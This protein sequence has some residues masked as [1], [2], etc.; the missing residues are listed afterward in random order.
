MAIIKASNPNLPT[1]NWKIV[2][3]EE[4]K[5][6]FRLTIM[7]LNK[8]S[9]APLAKTKGVIDYGFGSITL[10][11]YKK[12]EVDNK[13]DCHPDNEP[14]QRAEELGDDQQIVEAMDMELHREETGSLISLGSDEE[15]L[16]GSKGEVTAS[17]SIQ[18]QGG[19]L[20]DLTATP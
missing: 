3:Q 4:A 18:G 6:G 13:E 17:Q 12:D 1:G 11:V 7:V 5:G 14:P 16:L 20:S 10:K 8:E 9:L 19:S 2:K 15:Y